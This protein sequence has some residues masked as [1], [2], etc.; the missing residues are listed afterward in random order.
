M[1]ADQSSNMERILKNIFL[2]YYVFGG[3]RIRWKEIMLDQAVYGLHFTVFIINIYLFI[4]GFFLF[5]KY[6]VSAGEK[7]PPPM[8]S[9]WLLLLDHEFGMHRAVA[10]L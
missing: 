10:H 9:A 6:A 1:V 4:F 2:I 7:H 3:E 5:V 8:H